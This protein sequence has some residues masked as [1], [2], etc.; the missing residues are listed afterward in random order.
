MILHWQILS[1]QDC[2]CNISRGL[3]SDSDVLFPHYPKKYSSTVELQRF[4]LLKLLLKES[5]GQANAALTLGHKNAVAMF[6]QETFPSSQHEIIK[7][8]KYHKDHKVQMST[9]PHRA[10]WPRASAPQL[11]SPSTPP[12][13]VIPPSPWAAW[14][15]TFPNT[16]RELLQK[17]DVL[18]FGELILNYMDATGEIN[19]IAKGKLRQAGRAPAQGHHSQWQSRKGDSSPNDFLHTNRKHKSTSRWKMAGWELGKKLITVQ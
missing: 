4:L 18:S 6:R 13:M 8:G 19:I 15:E 16:Q 14:D 11:L 12:G 1:F 7:V 5:Y 3:L 10:H 9:H 17:R 2:I